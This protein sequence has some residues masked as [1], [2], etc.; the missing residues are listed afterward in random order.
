MLTRVLR[1]AILAI[2][3]AVPYAPGLVTAQTTPILGNL[4]TIGHINHCIDL[5]STDAYACNQDYAVTVTP[6]GTRYTFKAN[7]TNTGP[8]TLNLNGIGAK[9][10]KRITGGILADLLDGD[11]CAG[12]EV[13]VVY[14]GTNMQMVSQRCST[15]SVDT[16]TILDTQFTIQDNADT[17][18]QARFEAS[19]ITS[20]QTRTYTLFDANDTLACATCTQ[21]LS[22]KTLTTPTIASFVN[23]T[24]THTTTAGGGQLTDAALSAAVTVPKGGT[25]ATTL[26]GLV[27]GNGSGVMT[28]VTSSIVGQVPRVTAANTYVFGALDLSL[29]AA[30]TG[31]LP[32]ANLTA[33]IARLGTANA[34]GDG[35]KQTFNPNGTNAGINVGSHTADPSIPVNGD[36]WYD[37]TTNTLEARINGVTV[38][39]GAGG[40]AG[41]V[42]VSGTPTAGQVAVWVDANTLEGASTLDINYAATTVTGA[43]VLGT[44]TT[45]ADTTSTGFT[46]TLPPALSG[47]STKR[48]LLIKISADANV[49]TLAPDGAETING[50]TTPLT[51]ATRWSGWVIQETSGTNWVA[52]PLSSTVAVHTHTNPEGGG[53]LTDAALSAA[54]TVPKGGTGATTLT[55]LVV[56]NGSGIMTA[57]TSSIVGQVPR[58]TAANTYVFGALDLSLAAAVT[59]LLPDANLTANIARLGTTQTWG[60]GFKQTFNPNGTNAGINVGSH[61]ADPSTLVNGDLWYDSTTN[62]LEAR[63]NGATVALGTAGGGGVNVSG[64]PTAGQVA[65]WTN[66]N[67]I[68]GSTTLDINYAAAT[69]T[70]A[71]VLSTGTEYA[72]TTSVGFTRTLPPALSGTSTKRFVLLKTSADA[73]VLTLAP[74]G[75]ETINGSTTPLTTATRWSGWVIQETSGTNWVAHPVASTAGGGSGDALTTNPLSQFAATTS[76]QLAGVL[77]NET[78]TGLAV[79]ATSPVLTTP[80]LGTPSALTLTNATGLPITGITSTTS[81]QLMTLLSDETGTGLAVFATNPVLTTPNLGTPSV[82]TLTNATGLPI[83][84]ITSTTSA[85]LATLL[86]NETGTGLVVFA[87]SPVLTTPNLGT[88][89][90]GVLT[91]AT[92]LPLTTGVTGNLPVTN[93]NSGTGASATTF[94]RGDGTWATPAGGGGGAGRVHL[95]VTGVKFPTAASGLVPAI[96]DRSESNDRL[97]FDTSVSWCVYWQFVMPADY[98]G[99]PTFRILY[100]MVSATGAVS[101][102]FDVAMMAVTSGDAADVNTESFATVNDCNDTAVPG[103][104]GFLGDITCALTNADSVAANDHT[105]IRMCRD[106]ANDNA[107]GQAE[108]LGVVFEYVR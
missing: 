91:N 11:I 82:L 25:G 14:D 13:E 76:A 72:D 34:W 22:G 86:T 7:T 16:L 27:V 6:P 55:G 89:S 65:I 15:F 53:Q 107:G 49:L 78:G 106:V 73:N 43:G 30:V 74:D 5:G 46:Q 39:L 71:G 108:V 37:S 10:I 93:L 105:K 8:A 92:G 56:G 61:T 101:L 87:T 23:A 19:G 17:A 81:A 68:Q 21:T 32:D 97:L 45:Y 100:S 9:T 20:G 3:L 70:S 1:Y 94:W 58:V 35:V 99:T 4:V 67:T 38:A 59:G 40:G 52:H 83:T 96:L 77:S 84:G 104:A 2:V 24:H 36:L 102:H 88:P 75:A 29:A 79:F 51:T 31:L 50:S 41:T 64:T 33:N 60:D 80:N 98:V 28:A 69:V 47:T 54:V 66:A 95:P 26:T 62:T 48:F 90:A 44:G 85:Q 42:D 18:K 63:I 57:V 12:Q 103:T